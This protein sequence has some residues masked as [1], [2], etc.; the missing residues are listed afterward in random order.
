M[1]C[2]RDIAQAIVDQGADYLLAVKG[3]Q[4]RLE[5][6]FKK[7]FSQEK[8]LDWDGDSYQTDEQS[9]GRFEKRLYIVSDIF[10]E[11]VNFSFD[12]AGMKTLGIAL[13]ARM[14]DG[15]V[16]DADDISIRYYISSAEL[17]AKE[18]AHGAREHWIIENKL[19]WKLDVGMREDNCRIR[20]G[21]AAEL[22]SGI[23]RVAINL[24][25]NTKTFKAGL[26]RK[27]KKAAMSSRYMAEVLAGKSFRNLAVGSQIV[28]LFK[29]SL[30]A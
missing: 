22:L 10:D 17:T 11:F 20:R 6:A 13:S 23:G 16:F 1:D 3:N 27:Q 24:L 8:L 29:T 9:H 30:A 2:Q 25:N 26:K 5:K 4:G 15:E 7:H 28:C 18:F 12:W 21:D 19:H 14:V